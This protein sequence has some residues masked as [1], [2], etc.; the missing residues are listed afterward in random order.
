MMHGKAEAGVS[1]PISDKQAETTNSD[2]S[3]NRTM[4]SYSH[5][6]AQ[7]SGQGSASGGGSG[8]S[9]AGVVRYLEAERQDSLAAE[10]GAAAIGY[11]QGRSAPSVWLGFGAVEL[12]LAGA[13]EGTA[14]GSVLAGRLPDGTDLSGRGN[15]AGSRRLG[16][17]LTISAPKSVSILAL[18]GGDTRLL[19]AHDEAVRAAAG[20]VERLMLVARRGKAGA[21]VE[22]TGRMVAAAYRHEDSR[23]VDGV[24]D[25]QLHTHLIIANMTRR[26]DGVWSAASLDFGVRNET[27]HMLDAVYKAELAKRVTELGYG[28]ERTRD[29]FEIAGLT[30]EQIAA[31]SRRTAEIDRTLAAGGLDRE[32]AS[33]AQRVRANVSTRVEK[34]Q[35]GEVEQRYGWRVRARDVGLDL[36]RV[37]S[38]ALERERSGLD[39]GGAGERDAG[40]PEH[41]M[42][43]AREAV[44]GAARHLGERASVFSEAGLVREALLAGLGRVGSAEVAEAIRQRAGG[45]VA[46]ADERRGLVFTTRAALETER[47]VLAVV[48]TGRGTARPVAEPDAIEHVLERQERDRGLVF[49]AGQREAVRLA[50]GTEDRHVGIVGAAGSGKTRAMG[51]IVAAYREAGYEIVGLAPSAAAARELG[52]AGCDRTQTLESG[53]RRPAAETGGA[54][55]G[56]R[57]CLY[58]LDEAGMVSARDMDRL[59]QRAEAE[60]ARTLLVG[61]PRQLASVEA[62]SPFQQLLEAGALRH[63]RM[64][65]V[66]RQRDPA[67]R[68]I[69][70]RFARGDAAGAVRAAQPYMAVVEKDR[71]TGAAAEAYLGLTP[72]ERADTLVLAG[73]NRMREGVNAEIRDGLRARGELGRDDLSVQVLDKADL[74]REQARRVSSYE[75]GMVVTFS[76]ELKDGRRMVA[77]RGSQW[78]VVGRNGDHVTLRALGGPADGVGA[79]EIAWR[80]SGETATAYHA[81][82]LG[83][84]EGERIVFRENDRALGVSNGMGGVVTGLD[85]ARGEALVRSDAGVEI[86]IGVDRA[87]VIDHGYCRTIHSSQGATVERAIVV[88]EA[89]RVAT[90]QTAYVAASRERSGLQI[91]TDDRDKLSAAWSRWAE[92]QT[93]RSLLAREVEREMPVSDISRER[94][95]QKTLEQS[96]QR[97][98]ELAKAREAAREKQA[99]AQKQLERGRDRGIE[100]G[101]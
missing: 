11:Y 4:I 86:C 44:A 24:A 77:A 78:A 72:A 16:H 52:Q 13:V 47:R 91:I 17:D 66:Q 51:A 8:A 76:R 69:A 81:R 18:A 22:R 39:R 32:A 20:E 80:P 14:L 59:M 23:P 55:P 87:H 58:V 89:G 12:G 1:R 45:L 27:L 7:G 60:G 3:E 62:G 28:I 85:R 70:Q 67:L 83:L 74:T 36:E 101:R 49:T 79:P 71:L 26:S 19:A 93:A 10:R 90:A 43:L 40:G 92:R 9:I 82:P 25:P 5:L 95:R 68:E 54:A 48:T 88:G 61:D 65:E 33:A 98:A 42:V 38:I 34:G 37:R 53:L 99:A 100:M 96:R 94:A 31:F 29:G 57:P 64:D 63:V 6:T 56:A 97:A 2:D 50:L 75:T 15:R 73:T 35:P 30:R 41:A 21:V 46:G 84:A